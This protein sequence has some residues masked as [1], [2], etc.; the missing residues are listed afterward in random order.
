MA[1]A[2]TI[3]TVEKVVKESKKRNFEESVDLA[4][5]LKDVDLSNP[6]NRVELEVALPKGRGKD[7][8]VAV[9]GSAELALKAKKVADL[10]IQPEELED[11]AENKRKARRIAN[12]YD[13]FIAEAP[14]MPMIGKRLGIVLGPRGKMPR[15][16]PPGADPAPIVAGLKNTVRIR[17]RDRRTFHAPIGTKSMKVEDLAE[18]VDEVVKRVMGTLERGKLNLASVYV[19]TTMGPAVRLM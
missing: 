11:L 6:K 18:N 8:K 17:S 16:I 19:K 9:F 5:N 15:P 10:V 12:R 4:F 2:K 7:V 13:F 14:L 3:E 1:E